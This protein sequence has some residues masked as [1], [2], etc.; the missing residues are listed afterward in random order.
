MKKT[1]KIIFSIFVLALA[2]C[3]PSADKLSE[4]EMIFYFETA[5]IKKEPSTVAAGPTKQIV[6]EATQETK[7]SPMGA[8]SPGAKISDER[9][10]KKS[11]EEFLG[12]MESQS[13]LPDDLTGAKEGIAFL[14]EA[15]KNKK[16]EGFEEKIK[17]LA[18]SFDVLKIDGAFL[19]AKEKRVKEAIQ[20]IQPRGD[21]QKNIEEKLKD[22]QQM[23]LDEEFPLANEVFTEVLKMLGES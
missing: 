13:I 23:I 2:G 21:L 10:L 7:E 17:S 6:S 20:K 22:A 14:K 19:M 8:Q 11:F 1:E 9:R 5:K 12:K 4:R 3:S 18:Q 16:M 15:L